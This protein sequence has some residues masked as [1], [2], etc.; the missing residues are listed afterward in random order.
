MKCV[1]IDSVKPKVLAPGMYTIDVEP[2][3]PRNR[4]NREVQLDYLKHFKGSVKTLR[5]I[6]KEAKDEKPLDSSLASACLYTKQSQE[7]LLNIEDLGK[8]KA[9]TDIGIFVGYAPNRK[10][11]R[12]YNKRTRRIM[13][14]IHVQFDELTELMAPVHITPK[15]SSDESSFEDASSAESTQVTQPHNHLRKWSKDHPLDNVIGNPSRLVSTRKQLATDALWCLYNSVLSKVE[16]KNVKTAMD[17]ACCFEAMQGEIYKFDRLQ[18]W[19]LVPKLCYDN[20]PQAI[21]IF[22][23]NAA[24][25]NMIIYQIDVKTVFLNGDLKEEVYVSQ[26]EG[27][28]D[29]EHPTHVYRLKKALYGLKQAS[30][31]W[32]NTLSRRSYFPI[33]TNV[34]IPR[35]RRKK[36]SNIVEPEIRTIVEMADN[37]TMAQMLQAPIEG[38][39]DVI[40]VPPINAKN[41]ELKQTLINLVQSNQFTG[42][43]DPHNHLR[44][45]NK[46]TSTFR[47][48]EVSNTMIKLLLF[49]FSLEGEAHT[50]L[51]KEPLARS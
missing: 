5:E 28:V 43:Q 3:P 23:A 49:P 46:V 34:T 24:S 40:V 17:E 21:R 6:V 20:H 25:K 7:L 38:Y 14:T 35:R 1:T 8:L 48:P 33:T 4:N 42:R 27:F 12:I 51:D 36:I 2:I 26:P 47:H 16:P 13:E 31:A 9:T 50:W 29:P 45:F 32:Y 15:P 30:R 10:V 39:Q 18:V 37:H 19:E 41:F 44:F 11:Y 22:I